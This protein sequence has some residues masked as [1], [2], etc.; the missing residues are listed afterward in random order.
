M[1]RFG[2]RFQT[3]VGSSLDASERV[4]EQIEAL[5]AARP[6]VD[7]YGGFVG[8]FGGGEVNTGIVFV[9]L[10]DP[11]DRPVDPK[12]GRRLSQQD[13]MDVA[14]QATSSHPRGAHRDAGPLAARLQPGRGGGF[15]VEFNIRG[16]DWDELGRASREIMEKMRQSGLVTDVD[17]DYQVGMPEVQ[18][19][20]DRNKAADLG[21]RD[22]RHRRDDQLRD[23]R[24][25]RRQVQGQGPA[26]RHPGAAA[27]AAAPAARG[28]RSGCSCAPARAASCAWA[29]SSR[30]EQRPTLQT[31]TRRDRERAITITANVAPGVSQGDAIDALDADRAGEPARRLPRGR[32]RHRAQPSAS[33]SSRWSSPWSWA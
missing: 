11:A 7:I 3:P 12:T 27:G 18:V 4:L 32:L 22:G 13:L 9:T 8:G 16:R 2:I 10:K 15:P 6:E 17:S 5:P 29:T 33:R 23:R 28:H 19:V 26:L 24:P 20:P 31:I 21:D 30:I 14:R 1:S 25:A